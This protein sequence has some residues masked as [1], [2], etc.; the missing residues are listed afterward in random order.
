MLLCSGALSTGWILG[1]SITAV[2]LLIFFIVVLALVP[3]K[4]WFRAMMSS[5]YISMLKLIGMKL[6]K[7]DCQLITL[8]YITARKA[9]LKISVDELIAAAKD[10]ALE[11]VYGTGTAAVISPVG[12]LRY[13]D[14][15]MVIGDGNIGELSQKLY[16]TLTGI[17]W[18]I[19]DD[20]FGWRVEI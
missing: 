19:L 15:V 10:G 17:Q 6:R 14:D 9:G 1:I 20:P 2:L 4:L 18:G 16:D 11:E 8:N 5:A 7:V 13:M 3:F 12:K